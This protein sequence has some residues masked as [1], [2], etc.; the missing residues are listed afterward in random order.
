MSLDGFGSLTLWSHRQ[1][2]PLSPDRTK[3]PQGPNLIQEDAKAAKA[4]AELP[5]TERRAAEVVA[6]S[7]GERKSSLDRLTPSERIDTFAAMNTEQEVAVEQPQ[8]TEEPEQLEAGG[9]PIFGQPGPGPS[10]AAGPSPGSPGEEGPGDFL[11]FRSPDDAWM[12]PFFAIEKAMGPATTIGEGGEEAVA[13]GDKQVEAVSGNANKKEE[14]ALDPPGRAAG[15][16]SVP[17]NEGQEGKWEDDVKDKPTPAVPMVPSPPPPPPLPS[18]TELRGHLEAFYAKHQPEK[19]AGV[20]DFI[21]K[22]DGK[23]E[24]NAG[25]P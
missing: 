25:Q 1:A 18:K 6:M 21:V 15:D 13:G 14:S 2:P 8:S 24:Y 7:P 22:Y 11:K 17:S 16:S 3:K 12:A 5:P 20:P 9:M 4:L 19:V 23:M 10:S